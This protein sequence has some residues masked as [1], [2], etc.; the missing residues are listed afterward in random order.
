M[1]KIFEQAK[2]LHVV[3]TMVYCNGDAGTAYVDAECT[4]AFTLEE[5]KEAF[6]KGAMIKDVTDG[7]LYRP[8]SF[9]AVNMLY[10][11]GGDA[12]PAFVVPGENE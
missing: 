8:I 11:R 1:D 7:T 2:D 4:K 5:L 3:A 9:V 6:I 12:T 10:L